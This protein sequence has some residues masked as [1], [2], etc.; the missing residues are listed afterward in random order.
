MIKERKKHFLQYLKNNLKNLSKD[1]LTMTN[2]LSI[3][4]KHQV[5]ER[6]LRL[7]KTLTGKN[8]AAELILKILTL[9]EIFQ[10]FQLMI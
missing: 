4:S 2:Q 8:L 10:I 3:L 1:S 9:D 7:K 5:K 6:T